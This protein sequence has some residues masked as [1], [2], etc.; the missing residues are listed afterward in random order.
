MKI[1]H[2][3]STKGV[4]HIRADSQ[5][6]LCTMFVR[7]QEF[8]ESAYPD[9]R[10]HHFKLDDFLTRFQAANGGKP[11][12]EEWHGFNVPGHIVEQFFEEWPEVERSD[13][14]W[15]IRGVTDQ[16]K[17]YYLI[18][19]HEGGD[20]NDDALDH[21]LVHATYYLDPLYR[22]EANLLVKKFRAS[23][24]ADTLEHVL[25]SWHYPK[26]VMDDEFNA[27]LAT[28]EEKWW[29][30]ETDDPVLAAALWSEGAPFR[31]LAKENGTNRWLTSPVTLIL[32]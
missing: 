9:I 3:D 26:E 25:Q 13:G 2:T 27:Y 19:S 22:A 15:I 6:Q 31:A 16:M 29:A 12:Y 10:G 30:N 7:L 28:T 18:G 23:Q 21:E 4:V 32:S 20:P 8:Y 17:N 14:E 11:Y 1:E 24:T 5:H